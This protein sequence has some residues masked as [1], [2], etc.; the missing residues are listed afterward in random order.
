MDV[1]TAQYT[2]TPA[3][4][5][6]LLH[7]LWQVALL[8]LAARLVLAACA[9]RRAALRHV[10]GMGFLLSMVALPVLTFARLL[11]HPGA[12]I[13]TIAAL[14]TLA[15]PVVAVPG[16]VVHDSGWLPGALS[17][18]WL[19]GVAGMLLRHFGGWRLVNSLERADYARLPPHWQQRV[20]ALQAALR[21]GRHVSVRLAAD[22]A[23][24][25]TARLLRPVVWLPAALLTRLPADQVEALIA[26]EL[27]H[28]ARL[29][30]LWNGIQ[31]VVESLLFFHPAAWWLSRR[32]RQ[33]REHA[34]DDLAVAACG[35]AVALAEALA[36]LACDRQPHPRLV[37]AAQGGS[38]MHRI[39]RLLSPDP[40]RS[41]WRWP[42]A[43]SVVLAAGTVFALQAG[44]ARNRVPY[45]HIQSTTDGKLGPGDTRE[46]HATGLDHT[47]Y[48][49][50]QVDA[51]GKLT[52]F[53]EQDGRPHPIDASV[54][55]WIDKVSRVPVPPMPPMPPLP[56]LPPP[57]P[58][59]PVFGADAQTKA[60]LQAIAADAGVAAHVGSPVRLLDPDVD[61][62]LRLSDGD[63]AKE[64]H[65]DLTLEL[66]GPKGEAVVEVE[67]DLQGGQWIIT[68]LD[69][70]PR[71]K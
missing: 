31:C 2:L 63:G 43:I 34:C 13:A 10:L 44:A 54:R 67:A 59:P 18:L 56:P 49:L 15:T 30:W 29:D 41:R 21:I 8:A 45:L 26:H 11:G 42:L 28:I 36:G 53:Y 69:L 33:E 51:T 16:T 50:A 58:P 32:I 20:D 9:Q 17:V 14:P 37:L 62:T 60:L 19:L 25:F 65:A 3:L 40:A 5:L 1:G 38:L 52:E 46:I 24:P 66:G 55:T 47:R 61:G 70:E 68:T 23:A 39:T 12:A 71:S 6:T 57:P 4:A 7:S 35:D 22:L 27:A 64:G 48:Y